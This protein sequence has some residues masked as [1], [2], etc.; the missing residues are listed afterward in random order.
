[1]PFKPFVIFTL[2]L[3][4]FACKKKKAD[5]N[6]EVL[7]L[8]NTVRLGT[9]HISSSTESSQSTTSNYTGYNFT[10]DTAGVV[11]AI[12]DSALITGGWGAGYEDDKTKM[13]LVLPTPFSG[14]SKDWFLKERTDTKVSLEL[15]TDQVTFEKN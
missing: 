7:N 12:R 10:F 11:K 3:L 6:D 5:T 1:M 8:S 15:N 2:S 4:L 9:W 14:L 13:M